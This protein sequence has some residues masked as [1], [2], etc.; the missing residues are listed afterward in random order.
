M[1][2]KQFSYGLIFFTMNLFLILSQNNAAGAKW[3]IEG[4]DAPHQISDFYRA[5]A[6]TNNGVVHVAYGGDHLYHAYNDGTWHIETIDSSSRVGSDTSIAVDSNNK[7]H[8]SYFDETNDALKYITNATGSWVPVTLDSSGAVGWYTSIAVD[9]NHKVHIS[10]FDSTNANLKYI[11]NS[12]GSWV[13]VT[14]DSGGVVG[15]FNSIAIDTQD[16]VHI[17]YLDSTNCLNRQI[18]TV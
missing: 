9:S 4:I 7:V 14:L 16:K 5:I 3:L 13:P 12:T 2:I 8:I 15:A 18:M 1:N 17:S 10:Y 11:T 6:I